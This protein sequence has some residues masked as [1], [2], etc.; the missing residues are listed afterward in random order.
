MSDQ[1]VKP[2][3]RPD[4]SEDLAVTDFKNPLP[5]LARRIS[6]TRFED[7]P[8]DAVQKAKTFLID[9]FGVGVAGSAG[10]RLDSIVKV[11]GSWGAGDEATVWVGGARL[12]AGAAA[13]VN[14]YQ[15]HSLEFDCV[16]EE[17]V[18]HPFATILSAVLAYCERRSGQ[19]Q[20]VSG[21]DFLTA[22][23]MGVDMSIFLGKAATGPISFFRPATAGGFGAAA[24]IARLEGFD[25][26]RL[27]RTL[28]NQYGQTSGT[29]QPHVEGSPLLGMQ[30][31]FNARAAIASGDFVR[32]GILGSEDVLTGQYG[33]FR[34]MEEPGLDLAFAR[35]E[36]EAHF[37]IE[38][39]TH[40]PYPSGR[41][42]HGV[43]DGL[44]RLMRAHGLAPDDIA[45]IH[46][47]VPQLVKR[48]VGR[49]DIPDPAPNYAK[50]CLAFVAGTYLSHG[51]VDV[52]HFIGSDMLRDP[53][54]HAFASK[55]TVEQNDNPSHSAMAPLMV[56][57]RLNSGHTHAVTIDAVYGHADNPLT[58]DENLDKFWRCWRRVPGL[59][60]AQGQA[61]IDVVEAIEDLSDAAAIPRLL[62][63]R[64]GEGGA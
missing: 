47:E 56:E 25:E 27:I 19:G 37:Q 28:G 33:Y 15:I 45:A 5:W 29:L 14:A 52:E 64:P 34:L 49:P 11:A 51:A 58:A 40:K 23:V 61:L 20:P 18:L 24:A 30:V 54:T 10:F 6:Q 38:R 12:P 31:G 39:M 59:G 44:G 9:T 35:A 60:D 13:F 8:P 57:V 43:V 36:L 53:R 42:T 50:L 46:C 55:V 16:N 62:V 4:M 32:E 1:V 2:A 48:L 63:A 7:L 3:D 22:V 21:R 26:N 17:A 41:L